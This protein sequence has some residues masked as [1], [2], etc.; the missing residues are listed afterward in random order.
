M[1]IHMSIKRLNY[2][3]HQF[4]EEQDFRDEQK[5]HIEMRRRLNRALHIWGI[6]EGLEVATA[7]PR[8]VTIA[9]GF[10]LDRE[11][12]E[13]LVAQPIAREIRSGEHHHKQLHV[14]L[15][16]KERFEDTDRR[17]SGGVEGYNRITEYVELEITHESDRA[18]SGVLLGTLHVADDGNI[19]HIDHSGRQSA[20][21]LLAHHSVHTP[22]IAD[23]SITEPKLAAGLM[24]SLMPKVEL[25]DDSI[26]MRK[27][28]PDVRSALGPRGWVRLPFKP[29]S[30]KPKGPH[31]MD[32]NRGDFLQ[33]KVFAHCDARGAS[34]TMGIPVP[35]GARA[36]REFR[37]AGTAH[38]RRLRVQLFRTGWNLADRVGESIEILNEEFIHAEFDRKFVVERE[39]D[40]FHALALVVIADSES[41]IWLVAA[42]FE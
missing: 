11:G 19:H 10:A 21:S 30:Y 25:A 36:I 17:S 22:H 4:L 16:H 42:R 34:G 2:F 5:Y 33:D 32:E 38:G 15:V 3:N 27:L 20:S 12:R 31:R 14:V 29:V 13:L 18:G 40:D 1:E 6:V 7:G 8:E 41:E 23:G 35:A 39:L 26:T 37:I 9:P 28:A 24:E